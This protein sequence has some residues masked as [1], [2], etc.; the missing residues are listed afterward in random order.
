MNVLI[1]LSHSIWDPAISA[2]RAYGGAPGESAWIR[3]DLVPKI[4]AACTARGIGTTLVAGDLLDHPEFHQ[5]YDAFIAPHYEANI[6]N[7]RGAFWGRASASLTGEKD[8]ALGNAF[9]S[10]FGALA[11]RPPDHFEWSN[12][13]VT[14]YYGFRLTTAKTPGVLVEHGVGWNVPADYDFTWLRNN[15]LAIADVWGDALAAFSG[16]SVPA[17]FIVFGQ[18]RAFGVPPT[19]AQALAEEYASIYREECAL[20]GIRADLAFAQA[21]KETGRF[22]FLKPDG[23]RPASGYTAAWNNPAGLGVTGTPGEGNRF[24]T[25]REGVRAH[26]QHLIWYLS[27]TTHAA[28]AYCVPAA[29]QRHFGEH[30]LLGN[31]VRN[32]DGH[33]AVPGTGYGASISDVAESLP[34]PAVALTPEQE[35][36]RVYDLA[37]AREALVWIARLQRGLDVETGGAFDLTRPP[38]DPRIDKR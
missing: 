21:F 11:D 22:T 17:R 13:N 25:R 5:D 10:R 24:Q 38:L 35:A 3:D 33:W 37:Q 2:F 12:P 18:G 4:V 34:P 30:K 16:V 1:H 7:S 32:L 36:H 23:S 29:D 20:A 14:D 26:L 15:S 9:W 28:T 6:H 31:D 27:A 19:P 8:D